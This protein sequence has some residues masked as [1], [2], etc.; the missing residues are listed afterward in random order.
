MTQHDFLMSIGEKDDVIKLLSEDEKDFLTSYVNKMKKD[1]SRFEELLKKEK[2]LMEEKQ[3]KRRRN[4]LGLEYG[5]WAMNIPRKERFVI[6]VKDS[7][8]FIGWSGQEHR[9]P[10]KWVDVESCG[11]IDILRGYMSPY[12][13]YYGDTHYTP[14]SKQVEYFYKERLSKI[15]DAENDDRLVTI[16]DCDWNF[17]DVNSDVKDTKFAILDYSIDENGNAKI[18]GRSEYKTFAEHHEDLKK[19]YGDK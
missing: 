17:F 3:L 18:L 4:L 16:I 5:E 1:Q 14:I 8:H 9:D 10:S 12:W 19:K 15:V 13:G 7:K 11:A 6:A 2:S